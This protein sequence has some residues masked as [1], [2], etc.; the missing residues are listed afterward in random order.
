MSANTRIYEVL[1]KL[2]L[3]NRL[4]NGGNLYF[5]MRQKI[6]YDLVEEKL[7]KYRQWSYHYIQNILNED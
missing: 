3:E 6:D 7:M 5:Q 2:G 1:D 4:W